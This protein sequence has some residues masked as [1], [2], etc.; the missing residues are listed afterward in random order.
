MPDV[1]S[2][3]CLHCK[4]TWA[5]CIGW[6]LMSSPLQEVVTLGGLALQSED[7]AIRAA[8]Y[9]RDEHG[10][11]VW[12]DNERQRQFIVWRAI[13]PVWSA[14]L[15]RE[16]R[17][18]LIVHCE[19]AKHHFEMKNWTGYSG[20]HQLPHI[21]RDIRKVQP[22][23]NGYLLITSINPIGSTDANLEFLLRRV[24]GLDAVSRR[25]F[26]FRTVGK[27]GKPLE[28]WIAGWRVL[29]P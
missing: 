16:D 17:T 3:A 19:G 7:C 4:A 10:G 5:D 22:H 14:V 15:E 13:L 24:D 28:C 6:L 1:L 18:D 21:Q 2:P 27:D 23:E 9:H 26:R 11:L 12:V 8:V 25:D 20:E 29:A